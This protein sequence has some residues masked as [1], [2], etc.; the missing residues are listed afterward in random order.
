MQG[1]NVVVQAIIH[2]GRVARIAT[3]SQQAHPSITPIYFAAVRGQIWLGTSDWTLAVRQVRADPR[4]SVL[5]APELRPHDSR[6]V[7]V[8][9]QASARTDTQAQMLY[10]LHVALKYSLN[11]G[12][13]RNTL[14][15]AHLIRLRRRYHQQSA[16]KGSMCIIAVVPERFELLP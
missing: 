4:V 2:E 10:V 8:T 3:L 12:Q 13:L 9:G 14:A 11:P 16:A 6:I 1:D 7:R 5:I 15:H